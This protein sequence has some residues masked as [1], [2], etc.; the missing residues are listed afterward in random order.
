MNRVVER[1]GACPEGAGGLH[2]SSER[3]VWRAPIAV[4]LVWVLDALVRGAG[5]PIREHRAAIRVSCYCRAGSLLLSF[6]IIGARS[7]RLAPRIRG[8]RLLSLGEDALPMRQ[9]LIVPN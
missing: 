5:V 7:G 3:S 8:G 6:G 4:S 2:R 9:Q 1:Q